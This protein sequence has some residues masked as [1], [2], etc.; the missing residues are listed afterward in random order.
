ML[1]VKSPGGEIL[2]LLLLIALVQ[3]KEYQRA[4]EWAEAGSKQNLTATHIA[5]WARAAKEV[6]QEERARSLFLMLRQP[7]GSYDGPSWVQ[8]FTTESEQP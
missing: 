5:W 6:G 2:V 1:S 3:S 7:D 8:D 4:F